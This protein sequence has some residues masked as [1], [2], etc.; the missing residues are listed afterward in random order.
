MSAATEL[1]RAEA[2][3]VEAEDVDTDEA[4]DEADDEA[5]AA[6]ESS[7]NVSMEKALQKLEAENVRHGKRVAEIMGDDFALVHVCTHCQDFAAGFTLTPPDEAPPL[8][9]GGEF[10]R[11]G[12]CNG[13]GQVLTGALTDHGTT[14]TCRGC[15]GQGYIEVVLPLAPLPPMP[16]QSNQ[17]ASLANELRAQGFMVIDPPTPVPPAGA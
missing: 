9:H 16:G 17:H 12:K 4:E 8:V 10:Q 2:D 1:A 3:A 11:C 5:E 15:S 7:S 14:T 6:A 13:Y